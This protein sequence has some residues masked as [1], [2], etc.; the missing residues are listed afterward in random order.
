MSLPCLQKVTQRN[1]VRVCMLENRVCA[2]LREGHA[3]LRVWCVV[4][5]HSNDCPQK[6]KQ[7]GHT[8]RR[9]HVTL[10][11]KGEGSY[12]STGSLGTIFLLS[13]YLSL[14][15]V[16]VEGVRRMCEC[17]CMHIFCPCVKHMPVNATQR[18]EESIR[19]SILLLFISWRRDLL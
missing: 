9:G 2:V 3:S 7:Y 15:I 6:T 12:Q 4:V 16:C 11:T 5:L 17:V 14:F 1:I 18:L 10:R 19:C 13:P 8:H